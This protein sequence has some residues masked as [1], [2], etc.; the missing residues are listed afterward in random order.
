MKDRIRSFEYWGFALFLLILLGAPVDAAQA[1]DQK[2]EKTT[3][4]ER[5]IHDYEKLSP[6][7]FKNTLIDI[8]K[9]SKAA[10]LLNAGRGNP[11]FLNTTVREAHALIEKFGSEAAK[12]KIAVNDLGLRLDKEGLAE[13]FK[14]YLSTQNA[15]DSGV[16]FLYKA[17]QYAEEDLKFN[18]DEFVFELVDN[19][20]GDFYP[21]PPRISILTG[22]VVNAYLAKVLLQG[23]VPPD[24]TFDLFA[25]EGATAAMVYTF[26][27]LN[28]NMV[29]KKGDK[30]AILTP[31]FSPYLEIPALNDYELVQ[32]HVESDEKLGWQVPDSEAEKLLD[33]NIKALFLVNPTNPTSVSLSKETVNKIA[34]IVKTKRQDLIVLTDTVYATFVNDYYTLLQAIPENTICVYSYS[35]YFGV[36]GWRLGVIML[37]EN[38][39]IDA[40]IKKLPDADK[41]LLAKRY[42]IDAVDPAGI[43]FID[44]LLM[45]SRDVALA[46]TGGISGP[47]QGMMCLLSLFELIDTE[48][49]YKKSIRSILYKRIKNLYAHLGIDPAAGENKT[50]YYALLN[51]KTIAE[52]KYGAEFSRHFDSEDMIY[53]FLLA[54]AKEKAVVCLPGKGFSGPT[55]SIR[56]SLANLNDDDY[57][58]ISKAIDFIMKK[59]HQE[60][61]A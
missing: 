15:E 31:I 43:K 14:L 58:A 40:Y 60:L 59:F 26:K 10:D 38:N 1:N 19:I 47:Q 56:V 13:K 48:G 54:L 18:A 16:Q 12:E 53:K 49:V 7:E 20:L 44:R 41:R 57:T 29:I 24:T 51:L 2:Q 35:K 30:I 39:V 4:L 37:S 27:S 23:N 42:A 21:S 33:K 22:Q 8:A 6:F 55:S 17:L 9:K 61:E 5:Q 11:N 36:T 46:H 34:H 28:E 25:T 32:V 45:D 52:K 50:H 3:S